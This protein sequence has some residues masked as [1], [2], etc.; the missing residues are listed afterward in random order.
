MANLAERAGAT[1]G[2]KA[3]L[4]R[5]VRESGQTGSPDPNARRAVCAILAV[6]GLQ[7]LFLLVGCDWDFCGD[8]AEYWAWSRRLDWGYH[9]RGPLIAWLIRLATEVFG[10][11]SLRL[12][13]SL[14]FAARLPAVLLG[15]LTA[16]GVFR[17][18]ELTT[19]TRRAALLATLLLPAIPMFAIGG[20]IITSDTPLVC[21]WTWAAVWTLRAIRSG[22]LRPWILAGLI[23]AL[24][25]MAKY[26]VLALPASIGLFL[27]LS[28]RD[29]A[30]LTRPG[31]W[32]MATICIALGL[33]P[34]VIWNA[35][36]GWAGA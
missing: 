33:A 32:L 10:G 18:A 31:F 4:T 2:T 27:L 34:I 30:Q 28:R 6:M 1:A 11:L 23:G 22:D 19:G 7:V 21:C 9:S 5:L 29:R 36:H 24:G 12:T 20:V 25:V 16:W 13:G 15:G 8:E 17:L 3:G 26:S 35:R 14:M